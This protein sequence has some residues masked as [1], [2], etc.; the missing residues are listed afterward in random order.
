[1]SLQ[2]YTVLTVAVGLT[3]TMLALLLRVFTKVY[4]LRDMQVEDYLLISS[5]AGLVAFSAVL[6]DS[7][8]S[9]QGTHQWNLT[10]EQLQQILNLS[11]VIEVI[12]CPVML[13][14]KLSVL[15]Q[16]NR[17]F[18]VSRTTLIYWLTQVLIGGN[19]CCYLSLALAL[20]LSCIPRAKLWD[21]ELPGHCISS[22]S[23][24]IASSVINIVSDVTIL[25]LPVFAVWQLQ[26]PV[27]SKLIVSAAFGSGIFASASSIIR[28]VYSIQLTH[29]QDFSW[30]I[31]PVGL[32][33]I[34]EIS[35]VILAGSI[36]ILPKFV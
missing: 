14:A 25:I 29:T 7:G 15:F 32:W 24:I 16:L 21:P 28:L 17:I 3:F 11:N 27:K 33:A 30:G 26:L 6:V 8:R 10:I 4:I 12:Y 22:T 36:P 20:G 34:A 2:H 31:E 5:G 23:S 9:G 18:V 19:I 1:Y 35:T 13:M